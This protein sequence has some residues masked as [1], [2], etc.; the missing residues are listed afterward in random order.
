[1]LYDVSKNKLST[2]ATNDDPTPAPAAAPSGSEGAI[3]AVA[4]SPTVSQ[5]VAY[6]EFELDLTRALLENLPPI[7]GALPPATLTKA[8]V[9][10]LPEAAQG[11]YMLLEDGTPMYIGKTDAAHGFKN[12][13]YRHFLTLSARKNIDLTRVTFKAVRIMVFTTVNV[14][15]TLI[16]HFLGENKMAWQNSGFGSN[17]PGHNRENQ[18]PSDFDKLHPVNIDMPLEFIRPEQT[19]AFE[20]LL[21]LK[22]N[23]PYDLR[24]ETD[25]GS[26]NKPVKYTRG[27]IEQREAQVVVPREGMSLRELLKD[28]LIPALP[29]GWVA[30]VFPGRV[31]FYKEPTTYRYAIEQLK[32]P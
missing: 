16:K 26:N 13:L 17:D 30:T 12:R 2:M 25:L 23:L 21:R 24:Y 19:S 11:V 27:H 4:A 29:T 14:E 8:H 9:L 10:S 5:P 31:I 6:A 28:V 3:A 20:L 32:R 1:V 22:E 15:A 7:L 18:E